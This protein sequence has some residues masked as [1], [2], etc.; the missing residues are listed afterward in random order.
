MIWMQCN[1]LCSLAKP[2]LKAMFID[3]LNYDLKAMQ[4]LILF[5]L[6]LLF[7]IG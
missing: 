7:Y 3:Q 4:Y 5:N 2:H 6:I 1:F